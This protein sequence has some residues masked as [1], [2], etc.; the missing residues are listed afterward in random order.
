[1]KL[2]ESTM[3]YAS[4]TARDAV[5]EFLGWVFGGLISGFGIVVLVLV[6]VWLVL[7]VAPMFGRQKLCW[8]CRGKG[9]RKAWFWGVNSCSTCG[10]KGIRPRVGS[11]G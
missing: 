7:R 9:Y 11:G 5:A 4:D 2:W 1:M 3:G 10:G 8:R 6:V